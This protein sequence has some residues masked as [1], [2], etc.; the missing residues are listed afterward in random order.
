MNASQKDMDIT[1]SLLQSIAD[2]ADITQRSL[3]KRLGLALG[4]TNNYL[5]TCIKNGLIKVDQIPANRY[6]YYLTPK[7]FSEKAVLMSSYLNRSMHFFRQA[8][9]ES[10]QFFTFCTRHNYVR[11]ALLGNNDLSE[12]A[13]LVAKSFEI[14]LVAALSVEKVKGGVDAWLIADTRHAQKL[15]ESLLSKEVSQESIFC[16]SILGIR[17]KLK[18]CK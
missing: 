18:E 3:A 14:D 13:K 2:E 4:L 12:I 16:F 5:K 15:Y 17:P 10:E 8:R 11:V 6:L 7:G 9:I 1:L